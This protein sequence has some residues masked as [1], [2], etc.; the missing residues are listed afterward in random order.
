ML[1]QTAVNALQTLATA[2]E[3]ANAAELAKVAAVEQARREGASWASIGVLLG[4]SKQAAA[5]KHNPK[6]IRRD[7][8]AL[9]F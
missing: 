4:V 3:A 1:T 5:K 9:L 6:A 7:T 2:C 8:G